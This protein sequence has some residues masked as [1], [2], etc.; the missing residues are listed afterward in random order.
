MEITKKDL[1]WQEF[2]AEA[3]ELGKKI[4]AQHPNKFK[5]I[6]ALTRGGLI[7]AYFL[8]RELGIKSIKT[9]CLVSYG[10]TRDQD[11]IKHLKIDGFSEEITNTD[12]WLVVDDICD[13]GKT[14]DFVETVYPNIESAC[15]Y[16][17]EHRSCTYYNQQ[18]PNELWLNFPWERYEK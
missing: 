6:L 17:K 4:K 14:L 5:H 1:T 3:V 2:E 7:P 11:E 8:A 16:I 9:M 12:E 13:T 18:V 10:D 15:L